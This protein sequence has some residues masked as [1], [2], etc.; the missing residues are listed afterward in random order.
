[1][2]CAG[3]SRTSRSG[4]WISARASRSLWNSPPDRVVTGRSPSRSTPTA[5]SAASIAR[6]AKPAGQCHQAAQRQRQGPGQRQPLRH[7]AHL[8]RALDRPLVRLDQPEHGLRAGRFAGAVGADE[9]DQRAPGHLQVDMAE[10]PAFAAPHADILGREERSAVFGLGVRHGHRSP[11]I[12][13]AAA[14]W[15]GTGTHHIGSLEWRELSPG[16]GTN[17]VDDS[18]PAHPHTGDCTKHRS[19]PQVSRVDT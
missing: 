13:C 3:S 18:T 9:E 6:A 2:P 10:N 12:G 19:R 1:M 4:R 16:N 15:A 5:W 8:E 11:A 14:R 7:I 17:N